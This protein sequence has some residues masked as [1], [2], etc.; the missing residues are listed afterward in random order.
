M[1]HAVIMAGGAGTRM[2]PL[3]RRKR[4]KHFL[5]LIDGKSLMRS[6]FERL[7]SFLP[8]EQINVIT[9][10]AHLDL[11]AEEIPEL[12]PENLIG[13]PAV[14]DT[15]NAVGLSAFILH[16]RDPEGVMGIFTADHIIKPVD[17]YK[18]ALER[19]YAAAAEHVGALVTLG[20]NPTEPHTGYGYVQRGRALGDGVFE[21]REF[22]EKPDL[23]TATKYLASGEYYWNSG[24]F[25]W[26]IQAILEQFKKHLPENFKL[27]SRLGNR[28]GAAGFSPRESRDA[29]VAEIYPDL[30]KISIDY[31]VMEKADQVIL[32]E[33]DCDWLD[34]GSWTSLET[35]VAPDSVGNIGVAENFVALDST[36]NV[37]VS[38]DDHLLAAVGLKDI[39]VVHS[40]DATLICHKKDVQKIKDLAGQLH[41]RYL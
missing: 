18:A 33:M 3:S 32:C 21:V 29:I 41:D 36:N 39:V 10:T 31:G 6:S 19:A 15:A 27:L 38:D 4:P 23:E 37:F 2:W 26:R 11:V 30:P 7:V 24:M 13:E 22:K 16:E 25:V 5:K 34:V 40:R 17:R 12:P 35:V 14:R 20:I 28:Q 8:P 1:Q 9:S